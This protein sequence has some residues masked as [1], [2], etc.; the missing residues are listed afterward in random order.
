MAPGLMRTAWQNVADG[1]A[2][3]QQILGTLEQLKNYYGTLPV[4]RTI[5]LRIANTGIDNDQA[6]HADRLADFVRG[7]LIYVADPLNAEWIQ[8]PDVLLLEIAQSG[9]VSGDCDDHCLLFA[10]LCESIGI[11]CAIV[12][13]VSIGGDKFDHVICT[14]TIG[15]TEVDFDLCAKHGENPQYSQKLFAP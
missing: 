11:P 7:S 10:S 13:V 4:V 8:T 2:G 5:A 1:E 6:A 12:G 14:A 15:T 3:I 9:K